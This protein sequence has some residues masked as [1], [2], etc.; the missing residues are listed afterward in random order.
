[1]VVIF[2]YMAREF[3]P[4]AAQVSLHAVNAR[5][6]HLDIAVNVYQQLA[7]FLV[8]FRARVLRE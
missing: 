6:Q 2:A 5:G 1:V 4:G 8:F 7:Q 3:C